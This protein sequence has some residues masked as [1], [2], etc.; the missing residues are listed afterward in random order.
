MS[1]V[2]LPGTIEGV[3]G[4][5]NKAELWRQH[6]FTLLYCVKSE[7]FKIEGRSKVSIGVTLHHLSDAIKVLRDNK[8]CGPDHIT[9]KYL[10]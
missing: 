8:S 3:L 4:A 10:K 1:D 6:Y 9:S 7:A 5:D 2:F